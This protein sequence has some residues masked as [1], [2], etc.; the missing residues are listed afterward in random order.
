M[1]TSNYNFPII[2][3][4]ASVK[5][6]RDLNA[7]ANELDRVL[8]TEFS[9][10]NSN[11]GKIAP[12]TQKV[13]F[14]S[15]FNFTNTGSD[16][17]KFKTLLENITANVLYID[18]DIYID[19]GIRVDFS[20]VKRIE[21]LGGKITLSNKTD[22]KTPYLKW[23]SCHGMEFKDVRFE[24]DFNK[25]LTTDAQYQATIVSPLFLSLSNN[26]KI[27]GCTFKGIVGAGAV[28]IRN[29][30]NVRVKH[31]DIFDCWNHINGDLQGDG[32]YVAFSEGVR[33]T[34]NYIKNDFPDV[35]KFGRIGITFEFDTTKDCICQNN[36]IYGY[37]RAIHVELV[38]GSI[39]I[40]GNTAEACPMAFVGWHNNNSPISVEGNTFTNK[41]VPTT[42]VAQ[43]LQGTLGF[44]SFFTNTPT[45]ESNA[46]TVVTNND[47]IIEANVTSVTEF[48]QSKISGEGYH[49]NRFTDK[50]RTKRLLLFN[51]SETTTI[52]NN[53]LKF[54]DN[55][56]KAR[57][58][59][60][61][62]VGRHEIARNDFDVTTYTHICTPTP[63]LP[64]SERKFFDNYVHNGDSGLVSTA[65]YLFTNKASLWAKDNVFKDI[66]VFDGQQDTLIRANQDYTA[67]PF[68]KS[69]MDNNTLVSTQAGTVTNFFFGRLDNMVYST[70]T[71]K[72][73]TSSGVMYVQSGMT[74]SALV[75][76]KPN[77]NEGVITVDD[78]GVL[79]VVGQRWK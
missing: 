77:G 39:V 55:K 19:K 64:S 42:Y 32:V 54:V 28:M 23:E 17:V 53:N 8:G 26:V 15:S 20:K 52:N 79:S 70:T 61:G 74:N 59:Y 78:S 63:T 1:G 50:T 29:C 43:L 44:V 9:A 57:E 27:S 49:N 71:N 24:G 67:T 47:F 76:T 11:L 75:L 56:V 68:L 66:K 37:D 62:H 48:V 4:D 45:E 18:T 58:I 31:N 2:S 41:G 72:K 21:G 46:N 14:A 13:I 51:P 6:P 35:T 69:I 34:D 12:F 5:V 60:I 7:L 16:G 10:V 3:G 40:K 25:T 30:K 65:A 36:Y 22:S 33:V 38:G 73:I